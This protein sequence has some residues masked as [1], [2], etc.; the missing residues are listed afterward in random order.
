V[1]FR[2][3]VV[4]VTGAAG[5]IGQA[6]CRHFAK[7]G[8]RIAALD[9]TALVEDFARELEG[10][11]AKVVSAIADVGDADAVAKAF[12]RF[13]SVDIL[14]NN[15]GGSDHPT[16]AGTDPDGWVHDVNRNMNG[17]YYCAHAVLP[18]MKEKRGGS[19]IAIGSV[20][21]LSAFGDPAYSAAKAG[22][23]SLTQALAIEYG[24]Y[25]IRT[26][27]VAPGTVRTPIWEQR[28]A[29]NPEILAQLKRW[30]PLGRVV[31]PIDVARAVFF[32]ASD[33]AAAITG[34]ALPVDCGLTAG[35]IVMARE[36]TLEDF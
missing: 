19:I 18:G 31:D 9:Q 14:V 7:E 2:G 6:L 13:G 26:N 4:A 12:E 36:I 35:N 16:F 27:L 24:R 25:G 5:G 32:L 29:R 30:Y 22:M 1:S 17:A 11:G 23:F 28:V 15:A 21:G 20:N 8:A 33:A 10:E 34:V 3:K